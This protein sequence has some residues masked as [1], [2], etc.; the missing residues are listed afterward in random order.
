MAQGEPEASPGGE[1][2]CV[3]E[4]AALI[5]HPVR[6]QPPTDEGGA[7]RGQQVRPREA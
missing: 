6:L 4:P 2:V 3:E 1:I 7:P 5:A